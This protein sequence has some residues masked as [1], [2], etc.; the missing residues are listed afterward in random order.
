MENK[1]CRL[2][3]V[4][5]VFVLA[6][7][8]NAFAEP[9]NQPKEEAWSFEETAVGKLP[10]GWKVEGTRQDGPLA[11]WEVVEDT[12]APDGGKVLALTKPNHTSGETFNICWTDRVQFKDGKVE[13]N[14]KAN[15]GTEDQGGGPI[16]RVQ[17]K[18]N[19]YICRANPLENNF[20]VYYVKDGKRK[21]LASANA[22]MP[23][24]QWQEIEVQ[25]IGN[26]IVC[27]LNDKK[28]LEVDDATLPNAG[29]GGCWP[30]A[31]AVTACDR[32]EVASGAANE[33]HAQA[34][35]DRKHEKAEESEE[36][37]SRGK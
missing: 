9:P 20:R 12:S 33:E 26:H 16:W 5:L 25:H 23:S 14:F 2:G 11:T 29:G 10:D 32:L 36:H 3:V 17:D 35:V 30:T 24:G 19:Y 4:G 6:F 22:E 31:D 21:Q 28:L 27:S 18:D 13:L 37:K 8:L 34:G 1:V 15:G 7:G